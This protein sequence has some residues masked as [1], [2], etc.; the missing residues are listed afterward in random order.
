[1]KSHVVTSKKFHWGS[2]FLLGLSLW[3]ACGTGEPG[4]ESQASSTQS[5]QGTVIIGGPPQ[6]LLNGALQGAQG[7]W[8]GSDKWTNL[9]WETDTFIEVDQNPYAVTTAYNPVDGSVEVTWEE[10]PGPAPQSPMPPWD[11][12]SGQVALAGA[13][14]GFDVGT[15]ALGSA[16]KLTSDGW[17]EMSLFSLS[18]EYFE[19][20]VTH[21]LPMGTAEASWFD[22]GP[23]T[24]TKLCCPPRI[25][26]WHP[27]QCL[28]IP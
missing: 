5:V 19:L 6:D 20:D 28:S 17:T 14:S 25:C 10:F 27:G 24:N 11:A 13:P 18:G 12:P 16:A 9:W 4:P 22:D 7:H 21:S 2:L 23:S 15:S 8:A 26:G 3:M 1:M